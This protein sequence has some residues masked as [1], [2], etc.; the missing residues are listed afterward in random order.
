[1]LN[2]GFRYDDVLLYDITHFMYSSSR[3]FQI[4]WCGINLPDRN[5]VMWHTSTWPQSRDVAYIYMT[6]I[7]HTIVSVLNRYYDRFRDRVCRRKPLVMILHLPS[8][9]ERRSLSVDY[10]CSLSWLMRLVR[11]FPP[12]FRWVGL[13]L[14]TISHST[15]KLFDHLTTTLVFLALSMPI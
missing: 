1:M 10:I 7:A 2:G 8:T 4:A 15:L 9:W 12:I 13:S 6:A 14:I 3:G 11:P 5:L